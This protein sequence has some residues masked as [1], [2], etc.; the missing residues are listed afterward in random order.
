MSVVSET[1]RKAPVIWEF[2]DCEWGFQAGGKLLHKV[3]SEFWVPFDVFRTAQDKGPYQNA[4][5]GCTQSFVDHQR[6]IW[7]WSQTQDF[8]READ[9]LTV[10]LRTNPSQRQ[11]NLGPDRLIEAKER[12]GYMWKQGR[13]LEHIFMQHPHF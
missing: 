7:V 10:S 6:N 8:H 1:D 2:A 12:P 5:E 3:Q 9:D 4:W 13:I 11:S